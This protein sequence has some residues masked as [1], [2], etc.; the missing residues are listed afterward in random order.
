MEVNIYKL[1]FNS[2]K[3]IDFL[4]VRSVIRGMTS[5]KVRTLHDGSYVST[6]SEIMQK[7]F[8]NRNFSKFCSYS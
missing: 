1:D 4:K 7:R 2:Y 8:E 6:L 5:K 3:K